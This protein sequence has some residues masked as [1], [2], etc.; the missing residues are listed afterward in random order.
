[1]NQFG[2]RIHDLRISKSLR[3]RQVAALLE[4]DTAFVSKMEKGTRQ[5]RREQVLILAEY[6]QIDKEEL[7]SLW[8]ADK[9]YDVLKDEDVAKQALRAAEN[10]L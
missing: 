5:P 3:Q 4:A 7:L 1:M 10:K 2:L 9:V 6:F 8:L